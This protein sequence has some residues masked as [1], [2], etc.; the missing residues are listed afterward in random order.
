MQPVGSALDRVANLT[1]TLGSVK[2]RPIE[3]PG[4]VACRV[5]GGTDQTPDAT[6]YPGWNKPVMQVDI[7]TRVVKLVTNHT[8]HLTEP[9]LDRGP[10]CGRLVFVTRTCARLPSGVPLKVEVNNGEQWGLSPFLPRISG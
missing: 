2:V 10:K 9:Y 6:E 3:L 4:R 5:N 7:L 1:V 8:V